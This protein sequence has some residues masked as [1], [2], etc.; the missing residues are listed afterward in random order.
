MGHQLTEIRV[1]HHQLGIILF[2]KSGTT[3]ICCTLEIVHSGSDWN[4]FRKQKKTTG[5]G[6]TDSHS[7][8]LFKMM[9]L[10]QFRLIYSLENIDQEG[11]ISGQFQG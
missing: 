4:R 9:S 11:K 3:A 1:S 7:I 6:G 10:A 2:T 8:C 5:T